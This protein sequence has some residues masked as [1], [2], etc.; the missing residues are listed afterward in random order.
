MKKEEAKKIEELKHQAR[1]YSIAEG[2]FASAKTSVGDNYVQPFAIAIN[3]SNSVVAL[4]SSVLGLF[5]SLSQIYGSKLM[6]KYSRKKINLTISLFR[7]L[8]W[9]FLIVLAILFYKNYAVLLLPALLLIFYGIYNILAGIAHP[10]WFSWIGDLVGERY[11]GRWFSKRDLIIGISGAITLIISALFMDFFR[12][13]HAVIFGFMI[14]FAAAFLFRM[15][16]FYFLRKQYEPKIKIS[17]KDYFSFWQFL[18]KAPKTNFGRFAI[19]RSMIAFSISIS[20]SLLAVYLLKELQFGY[21]AYILIVFGAGFI[22]FFIIEFWGKF[23]DKYGNYRILVLTTLIIPIVPILWILNSSP[24]YLFFVPSL[25]SHI[26]WV[27]FNLAT[28]NFIYDNVHIKKRGVAVSYYNILWG[29]GVFFGSGIAALLI[30]YFSAIFTEPMFAIFMIS[31]LITMVI[32]FYWIPKL[33]E[34][35]KTEKFEGTKS[36]KNFMLKEGKSTIKE[37]I[38]QMINI[39]KYFHIK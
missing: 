8:F 15:G 33:K 12:Q 29:I 3:A 22:S 21:F 36:I 19:F 20:S 16:S 32:V 9:I 5:W 39:G 6:E 4:L 11:R 34:A 30:K 2:I 24:I 13:K 14:L 23:A 28:N 1:K 37:E 25:L 18:K 35:R 10:S 26:S 17:K 7:S 38:Y 27:G 31:A